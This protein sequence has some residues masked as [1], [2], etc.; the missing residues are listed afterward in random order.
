MRRLPAPPVARAGGPGEPSSP[1]PARARSS[2]AS[3]SPSWATTA[4]QTADP[5]RAQAFTLTEPTSIPSAAHAP[6][7]APPGD[8]RAPVGSGPAT[9]A[10]SAHAGPGR[11]IVMAWR[12]VPGPGLDL[13]GEVIPALH[14][15]LE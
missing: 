11:S 6:G 9:P 10:G 14:P 1:R 7:A 13:V 8:G 4:G 15:V 3:T 5:A 2:A 12:D